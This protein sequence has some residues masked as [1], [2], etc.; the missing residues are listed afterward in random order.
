[1]RW[2]RRAAPAALAG[3]W[4]L[5]PAA[6]PAAAAP[7]GAAGPEVM[8]QFAAFAPAQLDVLPGETVT[9]MN[10]SQ[11]SHTVTADDGSFDSGVVA[12]GDSYARAFT[13]TGAYPYHCSIHPG[14]TGEVDVRRVILDP[15]PAA[16]L[17]G[18]SVTVTGRTAD[19]PAPVSI[20]R[21]TA[22][23][24]VTLA[25]ATPTADGT[26]S[27][28]IPAGATGDIRAVS[29]ADTS[30]VR[31]LLVRDRRLHVRVSGSRISVSVT[32]PAPGATVVLELYLRERFGWWPAV[33]RRLDYLSRAEFRVRGPVRARVELVDRDG[34]TP[35]IVG[36]PLRI[37]RTP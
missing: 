25:T 3:L 30:E 13:A 31:R 10:M 9:W 24:A 14:M 11:R 18:R 1:M 32:P 4:A 28:A 5:V 34:W 12:G 33:R 15:L 29:G 35:L 23:A 27:A 26:W 19:G 2:L 22:T 16:V 20:Q 17:R 36:R 8:I 21:V 7:A 37:G 6:D